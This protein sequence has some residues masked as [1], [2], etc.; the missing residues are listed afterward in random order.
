MIQ[1]LFSSFYFQ[2]YSK[3]H[4]TYQNQFICLLNETE[5]TQTRDPVWFLE[6][7]GTVKS[8]VEVS[9]LLRTNIGLRAETQIR[10]QTSHIRNN[11]RRQ[12]VHWHL[13]P[14]K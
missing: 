4:L 10:K 13:Q 2:K 5:K 1:M 3:L 8:N 6:F 7:D 12:A 14:A 9:K 11:A